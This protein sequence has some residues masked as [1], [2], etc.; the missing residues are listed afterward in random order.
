MPFVHRDE[1]NEI[2]GLFAA[3][4]EDGQEYLP[5]DHPE[6]AAFHADEMRRVMPAI[7]HRQFYQALALQDLISK[8]AALAAVQHGT[9][10]EMLAGLLSHISDPNEHFAAE[11]LLSSATEFRRTDPLVS[12][13]GAAAGLTPQDLDQLWHVAATL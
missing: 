9:I 2:T 6:I 12:R 7:S 5:D 8:S 4:Q 1:R 10:P 3:E 11:M 13:F